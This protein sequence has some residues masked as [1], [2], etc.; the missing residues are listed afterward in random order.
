V[1]E[2]NLVKV[3]ILTSAILDV[4][5]K[6]LFLPQL[7]PINDLHQWHILNPI[8]PGE[9]PFAALARTIWAIANIRTSVQ[10]DSLGFLSEQLNQKTEQLNNKVDEASWEHG[11][12]SRTTQRLKQE[13]EKLAQITTTWNQDTHAAKQ[14][15]IVEHFETLYALCQTPAEPESQQQQQLKQVFLACLNRLTEQL[16]SA[17]NSLV[18][19]VKAWSQKHP[20]VKLL[21]VID[22]FEELITLTRK[23]LPNPQ[24]N[25]PEEWQQFLQLLETTLAANL[26]QLR[27]VVTLRSDFEPRFLN[28]EALKSYWTRARFPVRAMRSDELRQAIEGPASE[29]ALYFEPAN[30]VDRLIDEVGQMPGALPLLSF[31]LSELYIKLAEKWRD[32]ESSDRALTIDASFDKEGGVAGSLTR[33]ANE[34]YKKLG[35]ELGEAAQQT[36]RRVMLRMLTTEGGETARRRVPEPELVYPTQEESDRVRQVVDRLVEARLLVKGQLET[37]EPYVEPAHDFLVRGWGT[38]QNWMDE[39]KAKETLELQQRLTAQANDWDRNNRP[40]GLLLQDGDRLKQLKEILELTNNWLNQRETKFINSSIEQ[41]KKV[42]ARPELLQK[43]DR[44]QN[45]LPVQPLEGLVLAIEAMGQN[46]NELPEDILSS[47]LSSLLAALQEAKESNKFTIVEQDFI[48]TAAF[49]PDGKYIA[50]GNGFTPVGMP[51]VKPIDGTIWLR[52]IQG[53][54]I[55]KPMLHRGQ[56]KY[57]AF[58]S[59][60]KYI[61]SRDLEKEVVKIWDLQGNLIKKETSSSF[62]SI[63]NLDSPI[64]YTSVSNKKLNFSPIVYINNQKVSFLQGSSTFGDIESLS[65]DGSYIARVKSLSNVITVQNKTIQE[66]DNNQQKFTILRGG[67]GSIKAINFSQ[68]NRYIT[69]VCS[70]KTIRSWELQ[71]NF[72]ISIHANKH[73]EDEY[74]GSYLTFSFNA[75]SQSIITSG[76]GGT[77]KIWDLEGKER[78]SFTISEHYIHSIAVSPNGQYLV[79]GGSSL[80]LWDINGNQIEKPFEG[81]EHKIESVAF[82]SDNKYIISGSFDRTIRLWDLEGENLRTIEFAKE[83]FHLKEEVWSV[84][85]VAFSSDSKYIVAGISTE[86]YD[87][88]GII[89]LL[90][91]KGNPK[92]QSFGND[93]RFA[94]SPNGKYI[95]V[96]DLN[97]TIQLWDIKGNRV[98]SL[99]RGHENSITSLAFS[100]DGRLIASGSNDNT[101]KLWDTQ[102]NLISTFLGHTKAI[103]SVSFSPDGQY[104]ASASHDGTVRLWPSSWK[105]ALKVA[106][107]RLR[108]H[109]VLKNPQTEIEKQ[110]CKTCQKYVW[111]KEDTSV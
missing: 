62:F 48:T 24:S 4:F 6:F 81:H 67:E 75:N 76:R 19:I 37:G 69:G 40:V 64:V 46:L 54:P 97:N 98:G 105:T 66:D 5:P 107:N 51:R 102:G 82:S 41:V 65:I 58:S 50:T 74:A 88:S 13:A 53:K 22:Q 11:E 110:A 2:L 95:A 101:V 55:S 28:S 60:G 68:D 10:L 104:I 73:D 29:M 34:E 91:I 35:D 71:D 93:W 17:P 21:L 23:A 12:T 61:A 108:H 92:G 109:P 38:L 79:G 16:Q 45:L 100:P 7:L 47:T 20:G 63:S 99:F 14:L 83:P 94:L 30:L 18:E 39:E 103:K 42:R 43:A 32:K 25:T 9:L 85:L 77:I 33:R 59:N 80:H 106:C 87:F 96:A 78:Q 36:M 1:F 27:I 84:N 72:V 8:R 31:T 90:D 26:P 56:V 111:S 3:C 57:I 49:S 52:D 44:V 15:L 89:Q 70:D 86:E